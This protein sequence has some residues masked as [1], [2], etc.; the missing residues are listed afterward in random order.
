MLETKISTHTPL[1]VLE[2][3]INRFDETTQH[4]GNSSCVQKRAYLFSFLCGKIFGSHPCRM[5]HVMDTS[6]VSLRASDARLCSSLYKFGN[7]TLEFE[8]PVV[9]SEGGTIIQ[10]TT[11]ST[12][13]K[14]PNH[15][16]I[17]PHLNGLSDHRRSSLSKKGNGPNRN[18]IPS[19]LGATVITIRRTLNGA[20]RRT[21]YIRAVIYILV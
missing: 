4:L 13:L 10:S 2:F 1:L 7:K 11:L 19:T 20:H 8:L 6:L 15:Q 14:P 12:L 16:Y 21:E 9:I 5:Y 3:C 17:F 18:K